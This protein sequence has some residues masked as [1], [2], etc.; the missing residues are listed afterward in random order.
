VASTRLLM[1]ASAAYLA[2]LGVAASFLPREIMVHVGSPP[3]WFPE[4]VIQIAG[5]AWL[6]LAVLNWAARGNLLGGIYGRPV[7]LANVANFAIAAITLLKHL[8][9]V[10]SS[11]A[12]L[13][14][15]AAS[16]LFAVW[17]AYVLFGPGPQSR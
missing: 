3:G 6:A 9:Q 17:F 8:P 10:R 16:T 2:A 13:A 14:V 11:P 12:L 7:A 1:S 15:T 5:A 4:L